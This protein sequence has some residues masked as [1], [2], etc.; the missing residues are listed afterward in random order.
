MAQLKNAFGNKE[1]SFPIL[2][3]WTIKELLIFFELSID[4]LFSIKFKSGSIESSENL[5]VSVVNHIK[6]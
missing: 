5:L 6:S 4:F 2:I 3:K 1:E